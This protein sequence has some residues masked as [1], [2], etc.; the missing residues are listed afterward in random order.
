MSAFV[1]IVSWPPA[2]PPII[3]KYSSLSLSVFVCV[4]ARGDYK[5]EGVRGGEE[6]QKVRE[7]WFHLK[8]GK[9]NKTESCEGR[10]EWF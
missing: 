1:V 7:S 5:E 2:T 8:G 4:C 3:Y 6:R 9:K 10:G